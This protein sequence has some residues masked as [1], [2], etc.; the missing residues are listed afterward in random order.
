MLESNQYPVQD[1]PK[2]S[3]HVETYNK[4][5]DRFKKTGIPEYI[6]T[7]TRMPLRPLELMLTADSSMFKV[8]HSEDLE[9]NARF[10]ESMNGGKWMAVN[11]IPTFPSIN[12]REMQIIVDFMKGIS[13]PWVSEKVQTAVLTY[14]ANG[15]TR[16]TGRDLYLR[17]VVGKNH[18]HTGTVK[19]A[20]FRV[21][22]S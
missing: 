13:V 11:R 2:V 9:W 3:L 4:L 20:I 17:S 21:M 12:G 22:D 10:T 19:E 16:V 18:P 5:L 15:V 1:E 6:E 7:L 14:N 8:G